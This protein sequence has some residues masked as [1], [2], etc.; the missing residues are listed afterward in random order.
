MK[1]VL[2]RVSEFEVVDLGIEHPDYFQGFGV[3][4][5]NFN[6]CCYGIGND[7]VDA[8]DDAC[9]QMSQCC[10]CIGLDDTYSDMLERYPDFRN[11]QL[12]AESEVEPGSESYYHI[13][14]RWN[15]KPVGKESN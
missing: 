11:K 13:G 14:I 12:V 15:T 7:A 8:F 3:S 5:T 10:D 2:Q 4:Y 6:Y 9:E 1:T